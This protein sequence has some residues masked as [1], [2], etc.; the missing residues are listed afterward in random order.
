MARRRRRGDATTRSRPSATSSM[1]RRARRRT[2]SA[3]SISPSATLAGFETYARQVAALFPDAPEILE[4]VLE[5]LFDIAKADG[6]VDAAEAGLSRQGRAPLRPQQR[7]LRARQ[8]RGAGRRRVRALHH[9]GHRS[10]GD[11]RADPRGL[12]APGARPPSRPAD[13]AGPARGGDRDRQPQARADQRRLRPAARASAVWSPPDRDASSTVPS[14]NH[15]P[16][17]DGT[18][19][20]CWCCTTPNCRCRS[21]ST[22]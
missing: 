7:A 17:P 10:A 11:R 13:G 6:Q 4:N 8:G 12:A 18:S 14:P 16:R 20:T 9:A 21:R 1:C 15:A 19:S 5:G 3:S 22:S 2:C